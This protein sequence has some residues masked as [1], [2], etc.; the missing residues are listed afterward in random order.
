MSDGL[1]SQTKLSLLDFIYCKL[2]KK[3][4]SSSLNYIIMSF[5]K[6]DNFLSQFMEYHSLMNQFSQWIV[7]SFFIFKFS[8]TPEEII[9]NFI[10][11]NKSTALPLKS[12]N[13]LYAYCLFQFIDRLLSILIHNTHYEH[14]TILSILWQGTNL[15][16]TFLYRFKTDFFFQNW[17]D[18]LFNIITIKKGNNIS[19]FNK[20][21]LFSLCLFLKY[22]ERSY[23]KS[24]QTIT[25]IKKIPP[26]QKRQ[27]GMHLKGKCPICLTNILTSKIAIKCCGFIFCKN[28]I[29]KYV[30]KNEKCMICNNYIHLSSLIQLYD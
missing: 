15:F 5:L 27:D 1:L 30:L 16:L 26:L 24:N 18:Y 8:C 2:I 25:K 4:I 22:S 3:E 6:Q 13:K 7:D 10:K 20:V 17:I 14:R 9:F 12:S 29:E 19:N 28:C 21:I 23:N 11:I